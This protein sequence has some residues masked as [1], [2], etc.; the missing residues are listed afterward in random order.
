MRDINPDPYGPRERSIRNIPV[1]SRRSAPEPAPR[2]R[3]PRRRHSR[4]WLWIA[5]FVVL[6]AIAALALST[7]FAGATVRISPRTATVTA[8]SSLTAQLNQSAG[9]LGYQILSVTKSATTS[10]PAS[11]TK[12]VS[13]QASGLVTLYNNYNTSPQRLIAN[14]RLQAP[15]GK[16]YRIRDSVIIP[17]MSGTTAGQV[18]VTVYADSPGPDYNRSGSTTFTIPGFK[19]DPRYSKFSGTSQGPISGGFVGT[20]PAVAPADLANAT[21]QLKTQLD[22][23]ARQSAAQNIPNGYTAIPGTLSVTFGDIVQSPGEGG[24]ALVAQSATAQGA[25]IKL[26]DLASNI[27]KGTVQGYAGEAVSIDPSSTLNVTASTTD[28]TSGS[29]QLTLTGQV[30]LLWV[31]DPNAVKQAL[32]GK[33]KSQ[34]QTVLQS[35]APAIACTQQ[36]PC[37]ASIRPFWST[38][39]P[40]DPNKITVTVRPAGQ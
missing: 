38:T 3:R 6:C 28:L 23:D 35:F 5:A 36:E 12:Q 29:I 9:T 16:I 33:P 18:S 31:F 1:A 4:L 27:A 39:F 7:V 13:L 8:P 30:N 21:T 20:Q 17:G 15:D 25:V 2:T 37:D 32:L 26:A 10:V 14:T 40:T 11:G 19:G 22:S 34:F 24:T